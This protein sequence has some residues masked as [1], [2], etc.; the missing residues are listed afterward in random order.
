[1]KKLL[2]SIGAVLVFA[3][4]FILGWSV[5]QPDPYEMEVKLVIKGERFLV[6]DFNIGQCAYFTTDQVQRLFLRAGIYESL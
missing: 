2:S 6:C 3:S 1:M 4:V 5:G